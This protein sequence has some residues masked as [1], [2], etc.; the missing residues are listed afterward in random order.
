MSNPH[1]YPHTMK[2][3]HAKFQNN[4]CKKVRGVALTRYPCKMLTDGRTDERTKGRK[5]ARLRLP[6]KARAIKHIHVA[7]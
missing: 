2:K 1:A 7:G 4:G 5:L 6:A 3:T